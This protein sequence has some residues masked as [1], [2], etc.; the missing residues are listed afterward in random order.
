MAAV[1]R[2][3]Q[4]PLRTAGGFRLV[5]ESQ[6]LGRTAA[7][8]DDFEEAALALALQGQGFNGVDRVR[9]KWFL[10]TSIPLS[11]F[12]VSCSLCHANFGPVDPSQFVGGLMLKVPIDT[13]G[14]D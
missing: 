10:R 1:A 7:P 3:R 5:G 4:E 13:D 6:P 9:G 2:P 11:N 8:I 14:Q 12:D